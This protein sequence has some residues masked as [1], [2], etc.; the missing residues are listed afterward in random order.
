LEP[1]DRQLLVVLEK[2][3]GPKSPQLASTLASESQALRSLGRAKEAADVDNRLASIR[4]A[5]M[6]SH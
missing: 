3:Y 1:C 4:S 5:T 6:N 2:Q